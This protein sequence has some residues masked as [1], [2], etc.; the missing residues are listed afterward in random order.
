[1]Y[2]RLVVCVSVLLAARTSGSLTPAT[3]Q[4]SLSSLISPNLCQLKLI[5]AISKSENSQLR[6]SVFM[7]GISA[8]ADLTAGTFLGNLTTDAFLLQYSIEAGECIFSR[9]LANYYA[10]CN[11][12]LSKVF[13]CMNLVLRSDRPALQP[14]GP[15]VPVL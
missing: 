12:I 3:L 5:C 14:G 2:P 13:V 15:P 1:M 6:E 10:G 4:S 9:N 8:L 11:D 7:R